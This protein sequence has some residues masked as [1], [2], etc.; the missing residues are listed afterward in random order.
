M[1]GD[2]CRVIQGFAVDMCVAS[3]AFLKFF[4]SAG[5]VVGAD[6]TI[7][8]PNQATIFGAIFSNSTPTLRPLLI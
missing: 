4:F 2:K 3:V 1:R 7:G 6:V 5:D 8:Y